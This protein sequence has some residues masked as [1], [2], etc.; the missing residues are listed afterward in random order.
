MDARHRS[1][2][3]SRFRRCISSPSNVNTL[4]AAPHSF[5]RARAMV[6]NTGWT[7]VGERLMTRRISLVAVCCSSASVRSLLRAPSSVNRRTFSIAIT[8]WSANVWSSATCLSEKGPGSGRPTA[9]APIGLAVAI[10]GTA[11][12]LRKPV[13]CD[14]L[15]IE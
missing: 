6:S 8:A 1:R 12:T 11:S 14:A 13:K 3:A 15:P 10:K 5:T 4:I 2:R 9:M 7:S